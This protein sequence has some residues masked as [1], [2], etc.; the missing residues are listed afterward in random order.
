MPLKIKAICAGF[1]GLLI[2]TTL[3]MAA[4]GRS[5]EAV[6]AGILTAAFG[7]VVLAVSRMK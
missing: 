6:G 4:N 7:G 3:A 1:A 2:G 5:E